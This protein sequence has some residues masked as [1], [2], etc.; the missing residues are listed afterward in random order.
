MGSHGQGECEDQIGEAWRAS[1]HSSWGRGEGVRHSRVAH[2]PRAAVLSCRCVRLSLIPVQ[3]GRVQRVCEQFWGLGGAADPGQGVSGQR[4]GS[5]RLELAA[6]D[7]ERTTAPSCLS[8]LP[9]APTGSQIQRPQ[10]WSWGFG[11]PLWRQGGRPAALCL[12]ACLRQK[13][14]VGEGVRMGSPESCPCYRRWLSPAAGADPG[15]CLAAA[16]TE[17]SMAGPRWAVGRGRVFPRG[18]PQVTARQALCLVGVPGAGQ[19]LAPSLPRGG[20]EGKLAPGSVA[21]Q[22]GLG[23]LF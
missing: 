16:C 6:K 18:T 10:P 23:G 9:W 4:E 20:A 3:L 14:A 21:P 15:G 7:S 8:R 11:L 17:P 5:E 12:A 13:L 2:L 19:Q 1:S 22:P